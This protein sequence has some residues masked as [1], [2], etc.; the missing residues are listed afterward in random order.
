MAKAQAKLELAERQ[1]DAATKTARATALWKMADNTSLQFNLKELGEKSPDT[2]VKTY[3][4]EQHSLRNEQPKETFIRSNQDLSLHQLSASAN[5]APQFIMNTTFMLPEDTPIGTLVFRLVAKDD[6][7]DPLYYSIEGENAYYFSLDRRTGNVTLKQ[8]VDYEQTRFILLNAKVTD[9][10]NVP[11]SIKITIIVNDGNDNKPIF[12]KE[13]Y[14]TDVLENTPIGTPIYHVKA[15]DF[16]SE[17][18]GWVSYKI[19]E[20]IPNNAENNQLFYILQNGTVVLNGSLSYNNKSTFYRIKIFATDNGGMW[21]GS[22]IKQNNT[23]YISVT[24]IDVPDLDPGFLGEPYVASVSEN[25]PLGTPVMTVLAIDKDKDVNDVILY[26][27][28]N[29]SGLFTVNQ[30]TGV[31]TV[32]SN[33]DREGVPGEEVQFQIVAQEKNLNIYHEVAQV[34]SQVTIHINDVNDNKPQFYLCTGPPCN[35]KG[36]TEVNFSGQIEEHA[37]ARTPVTNLSIVAYDPD[38]IVANDTSGRTVDC[39]SFATVTI[40]LI[41]INDHRPEFRQTD[42][43]LFVLEDSPPGSIVASNITA[44]DPDSG[45]FG[46]ITYQLL[47]KSIQTDFTVNSMNGTIFVAN[48]S[49][50][51]WGKR[52]IYYATLQAMDGGGLIGS[53]Q[54]EITVIDINN[55]PPVVIG[56]YNFMVIEG[57]SMEPIQIQATDQDNPETNNSRLHF[58]IMPGEFSNN[59]TI[60][61][62]TGELVSKGPLDREAIPVELNGKIVVTILIEDLGI[63]RLNT[64]VNVTITVEDKNDNAPSFSSSKYEFSVSEGMQGALVGVV[65]ARDADQTQIHNRISF[66]INSSTGSSN[67]LIRSSAKGSGW[68]Q[69]TL[70]LDPD[71][72][73]DY[74]QMQEKF[75]NLILRAENSDLGETMKA[76]IAMVRVY[77]LDVNDESPTI[78]PS[79]PEKIHVTENENLHTLVAE[80]EATDKDTNHSLVFQEIAVACFNSTGSVGTI[81]QHWFRLVANG[82]LFVNSSDI[83]YEL[84]TQV[85]ITLR[86]KDEFTAVGNP[87]SRNETLVILIGDANDNA[88][89]FYPVDDT[90]VIIPEISPI[91]LSVAVVKAKDADSDENGVITF[92][93]SEVVLIQ[94]NGHEQKFSD[95]FKVAKTMEKDVSVGNILIASN[96]NSMLKGRYQVKVEAKD[97]GTQALSNFTSLD[98]FS[99]DKSYRINLKF[100]IALKEVQD[101]SNEIKRILSKATGTTIY[102][103]AIYTDDPSTSRSERALE[104]TAMDA[105]FV[106]KNG[107]AL[108]GEQV[109]MLIRRNPEQYEQL[110]DLG[111]LVI[112]PGDVK[113]PEKGMELFGIIIGLAAAVFILLLLLTGTIIGMRKSYSRKLKALKALKVASHFSP[114]GAQ[115][116]SAIPGTNKYNTEGANPVLGFS[117]D[118]SGFEENASSEVASLNSLDENMVDDVPHS[119]FPAK[120]KLDK[121]DAQQEINNREEPLKA[122]LDNHRK[123]KPL[124]PGNSKQPSLDFGNS[125]LNTTEL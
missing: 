64:T 116:G 109:L 2:W 95:V 11:T 25:C 87:Y 8:P 27:V 122:A 103:T 10:E 58:E 48:G 41:D 38:K 14:L 70:Y 54:L 75:F 60:H 53:T 72:A 62:D 13:P 84:C 35:F 5:T 79:P 29:A 6:E 42:Y 74:D 40:H 50:I 112:G 78:V 114:N 113:E 51:N 63:P 124:Q 119:S 12:Q 88:P 52:P 108:T 76:A 57:D 123:Y 81:C 3:M 125:S 67:F 107:T 34:T 20:V 105:Y 117:L 66:Y 1:R 28:V 115:Q 97:N 90:F 32:S 59:F 23:A 110:I 118:P 46:E 89:Q 36:P 65:E 19:I 111:L 96:L 22:F 101:N 30:S 121:A 45:K 80:L 16:D 21:N 17:N 61:P 4:N 100:S 31:I 18:A 7:N 9:G 55:N 99:V 24:V 86:V 85:E 44:I 92:S 71:V 47:P 82:S 15:V 93:I 77:V 98:I 39:C 94:D 68:Y 120:L 43:K 69:G 83:D 33:L 56:T 37:S 49:K 104:N 106:Y 26:S 73:L 91:D 102:I